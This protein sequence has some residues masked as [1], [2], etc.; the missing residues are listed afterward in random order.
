MTIESEDFWAKVHS[1]SDIDESMSYIIETIDDLFCDGHFEII[2]DF[3]ICD[4]S[5]EKTE[6]TLSLLT[7]TLCIKDK[8]SNRPEFYEDVK[9]HYSKKY[10]ESEMISLLVGLK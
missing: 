3:F 9:K 2:N 8:L 5:K 1:I 10:P 6:N 7:A 4:P